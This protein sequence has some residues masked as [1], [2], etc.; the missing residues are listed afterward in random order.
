MVV[1]YRKYRPQKLSD[2][3]GQEHIKEML[4]NSFKTGKISHAYLFVGPRGTGKT[5]TARILAKMLNCSKNAVNKPTTNNKSLTTNFNEPC[6]KCESCLSITDGSYLDVIEIDAASNRGIDDIRDL[7]EKIKLAPAYGCFKVYIIDEVHMLTGEAFNALLKTLEEPPEHTVFILC[8][9]E[10][11]KV[12]ETISSRCHKF[13]FKKARMDDIITYLKRIVKEEKID[14]DD[15]AL[16]VVAQRSEGAFRNAASLL[17]QAAGGGGKITAE[18]I[19]QNLAVSD[20]LFLEKY[21]G[22]LYHKKVKEALLLI[23]KYVENGKDINA[24]V[25][26]LLLTIEKY[27]MVKI[28][29][30]KEEKKVDFSLAELRKLAA[31][32]SLAENEMKFSFVPELPLELLTIEWCEVV[33]KS[34]DDTKPSESTSKEEAIENDPVA[35]E[36]VE[37]KSQEPKEQVDIKGKWADV[38]KSIKPYNHSLELLLRKCQVQSFDGETLSLVTYYKLHKDLLMH[39]KNYKVIRECLQMALGNGIKLELKL[40]EKKVEALPENDEELIQAAEEL[41]K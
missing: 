3:V 2:L 10:P 1:L 34:E 32:L 13:E 31:M 19:A 12:P 38:L 14:I 27:L 11:K 16:Q 8:T 28:E 39:P 21:L 7:R 24:F 17:D 36:K 35:E 41:F 37:T 18:H 29:V 22:F 6:N 5:T 9:T 20:D 30:V 26:D 33:D 40:E 15:M 23:K 4:L 25:R